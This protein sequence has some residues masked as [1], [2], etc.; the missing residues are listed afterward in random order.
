M[1]RAFPEAPSTWVPPTPTAGKSYQI[2]LVT[3]MV[4]GGA[5][6]GQVDLDFPIRP[7]AIRGHLRHWWRLVRGHS[8]G[9]A[10]WRREE[11][12]F[13]STEFPSPVTVLM[14]RGSK[15]PRLFPIKNISP[16]STHGY[17]LF[18]AIDKQQ[19][20]LTEGYQFEL[21]LKACTPDE[22]KR[23][24]AT[25]NSSRK[26]SEQLPSI[27]NP[28]DDDLDSAIDAWITFGGVGARTRRGCGAL[29]LVGRSQQLTEAVPPAHFLQSML[30]QMPAESKVFQPE[31]SVPH[32]AAW[33]IVIELLKKFR[34]SVPARR[35]EPRRKFPEAE[36]LRRITGR[37]SSRSRPIPE[38]DLPSGFPRAEL[39]LPIVFQ[40]KDGNDPET[41]NVLPS[42][43][44][45]DGKTLKRMASPL[46]L[47]PIPIS[48]T[49]SHPSIILL[50]K[51]KDLLV[52]VVDAVTH[53]PVTGHQF[54]EYPNSPLSE[55][56]TGSAIEA[57]IK[58][59]GF[60][61][62]NR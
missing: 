16:T 25:Q 56:A 23:R 8:L 53:Q 33:E 41:T 49:H 18:P 59:S 14:K 12:I 57:F 43:V 58:Y 27:I 7:T 11:E 37:R 21:I 40:F 44:D 39:G 17:I 24:R 45:S 60:N 35:G 62:V 10:M 29:R 22:L 15:E 38:R 13:G 31:N 47:K 51:P 36:T 52:D 61:E 3:P 54:S 28:I 2:E 48:P 1:S 50:R 5:A 46:I 9:E 19:D 6:A 30:R 55:S 42:G 34:Q 26:P 20:L 4:G 32:L